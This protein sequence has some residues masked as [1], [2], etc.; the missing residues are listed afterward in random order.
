V[1]LARLG[2]PDKADLNDFYCQG[3]TRRDVERLIKR[4]RRAA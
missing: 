3:G 2:L 1:R 4:E